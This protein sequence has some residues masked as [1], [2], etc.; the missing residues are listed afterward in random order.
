M[1]G[2]DRDFL[3]Q[4]TRIADALEKQNKLQESAMANFN[5]LPTEELSLGDDEETEED[6]TEDLS[7][8]LKKLSKFK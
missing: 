6:G 8:L 3:H 5:D 2:L 4:L 1:T 7:A